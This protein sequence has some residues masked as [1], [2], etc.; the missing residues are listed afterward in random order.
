MM[1]RGASILSLIDKLEDA[2]MSCAITLCEYTNASQG[3][4]K[5]HNGMETII[6]R[7]KIHEDV[8]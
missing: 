2:G 5:F 3:K 1:R 7:I 4:G 8:S 6:N